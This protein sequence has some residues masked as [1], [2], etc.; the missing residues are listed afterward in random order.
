MNKYEKWYASITNNAKQRITIEYVE[1]HHIIPHS[2][3]GSNDASNLVN[4]TA[5]EHFICH[6][7]L[8]KM[9]TSE[10]RAKM[11]NALYMMR[12]ESPSQ[13]RYKSKIT[14]RIYKTLREE[15][16]AYISKLNTG[17]IQP[18]EEKAKQL[19][20]Q[21]GRKRAPFSDEWKENLSKNHKS[22]TGYDCSLSEET[23]K[24]I[25]E[26]AKGRTQTAETIE[27][28]VEKLRGVPR[29][30]LLCPHCNQL[31]AVNTYPRWHGDNCKY[32]KD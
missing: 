2:L 16:A 5:R 18:P 4:L 15:Y 32:K 6:W 24:K 14:S 26:K 22:K 30:K 8:T 12:A 20:T 1:T 19:A 27:R 17:R 21:I 7:L 31:I 10:A 28:R 25:S 13:K 3:G 29:P 23:K 9:H 11:I